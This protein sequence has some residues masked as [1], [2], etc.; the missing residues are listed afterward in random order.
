MLDGE[1][2]RMAS[3]YSVIQY[4]PNP[5]SDEKINLGVLVFDENDVR[6]HFL[7]SW[8]RIRCFAATE[9]IN[10]LKNFTY[11]MQK[12][13]KSGLLFP[14]DSK[15][16][17]PNHERLLKASLNWQNSIQLTH[18]RGSLSDI[19]KLLEEMVSIYLL[20]PPE[21]VNRLRDRQ[22]AA[23]ITTSSIRDVFKK[24]YGKDKAQDF[25]KT[26]F[27]LTGGHKQ[28]KFDVAI[29]NGNPYLA[30]HG[31]SFE[32]HTPETTQDSVA[33][34]IVDV[35]SKLPDFP[36]A[37]VAL[38]PT[39]KSPDFNRLKSSYDRM[40]STYKDLGAMVVSEDNIEPWLMEQLKPMNI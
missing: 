9:E 26:S 10:F 5:I 19:D 29:A 40:T 36:L 3:R 8:K 32:V 16:D 30:A 14:G 1:I 7:G 35:K 34:M 27:P 18:P 25:V 11:N 4:V 28:H 39:R 22:A 21:K 37:V 38:P 15:S 24:K 6:V 13:V 23:Q 12:A 20:E 33:F 31:I 2:D 17:I